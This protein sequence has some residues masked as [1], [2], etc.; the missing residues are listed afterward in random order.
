MSS[1]RELLAEDVLAELFEEM[2]VQNSEELAK[3]RPAAPSRC[4]LQGCCCLAT[5]TTT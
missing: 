4:R 2:L 3:N 1:G 5:V